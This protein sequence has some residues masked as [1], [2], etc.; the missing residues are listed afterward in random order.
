M[1]WARIYESDLL[2][3]A[4]DSILVSVWVPDNVVNEIGALVKGL[5]RIPNLAGVNCTC[6][7]ERVVCCRMKAQERDLL[8]MINE[9]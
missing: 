6:A 7:Q 9:I 3:F 1:L 4:T 2:V 5:Y 8:S